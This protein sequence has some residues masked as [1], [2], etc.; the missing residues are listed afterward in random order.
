MIVSIST[1]ARMVPFGSPNFDWASRNISFHSRASRWLS[2]LGQIEI[3]SSAARRRLLGVVE[4]EQAE[5]EQRPR[6]RLAVDEDML[7]RKVPTPRAHEQHRRFVVQR[8]MPAGFRIVEGGCIW[9]WTP[10][11]TALAATAWNGR[12]QGSPAAA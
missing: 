7:F 5:V 4:K 8:I 11:P 1:V 10:A 2:I 9:G 3:R 6:D 12:R